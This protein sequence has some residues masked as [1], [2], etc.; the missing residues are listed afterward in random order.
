MLS[1]TYFIET[2]EKN[3]FVYAYLNALHTTFKGK[4]DVLLNKIGYTFLNEKS[5]ENAIIVFEE[6]TK[7]FPMS[8]N[9]WDSLG[10]AYFTKKDKT[11]ALK[12]YKKALELDP[13]SKSI[14][15]MIKKSKSIT[16]E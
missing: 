16:S 6:N 8:A 7:L 1:L 11:N 14:Q 2:T 15:A 12:S 3:A 10:E 9:S 13:D 4:K 5:V